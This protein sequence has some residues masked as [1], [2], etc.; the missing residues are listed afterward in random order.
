[1]STVENQ[2]ASDANT[3]VLA[4]LREAARSAPTQVAGLAAWVLQRP[5]ELA[6]R[7][8]RS[9]AAEAQVN[10][11]T[12]VRLATLLGFDGYDSCRAAFQALVRQ[13][14]QNY[15]Q[16][17]AA[18]TG[19]H[20]QE[21]F[22]QIHAAYR[23][24][25]EQLFSPALAPEIA[26]VARCLIAARNVHC[27]GVRSCFGVAHYFGYVGG[28]AFPQ[29]RP[30]P[31]Q[32]GAFLDHISTTD[33]NDVVVAITYAH[34]SNEVV[35][36]CR[37]GR[38]CGAKI[39]ALTDNYNSPIAQDAAHVITLPMSGPGFM[40]SLISAFMAV[41]LILSEMTALSPDAVARI[42]QFERRIHQFGGYIGRQ[43]NR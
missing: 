22:S 30:A 31:A 37:I 8:V 15:A 1:M 17:A 6:F 14:T 24:N 11:N 28:M 13:N 9:L 4:G 41:E 39:V 33:K 27:I 29:I 35:Q 32:P 3:D 18:L 16:R 21:V 36:A 40:P 20:E 10:A 38:A 5:E 12:V 2:P 23:A 19:T 7:S 42:E 43:N 34:Y 25:T 26:A